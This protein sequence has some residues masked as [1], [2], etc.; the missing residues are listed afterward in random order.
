MLQEWEAPPEAIDNHAAAI[1]EQNAT[2]SAELMRRIGRMLIRE[3]R[4]D[5]WREA[6]QDYIAIQWTGIGYRPGDELRFLRGGLPGSLP[7]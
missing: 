5:L 2:E 6:Y 1:C 4:P 7:E 3:G